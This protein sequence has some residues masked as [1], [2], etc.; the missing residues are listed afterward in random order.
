MAN[1]DGSGASAT[2]TSV[3]SGSSAG[4]GG[5]TASAGGGEATGRRLSLRK[6]FR[7]GFRPAPWGIYL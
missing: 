2:M 4:G 1:D 6:N 3:A 5:A 7:P